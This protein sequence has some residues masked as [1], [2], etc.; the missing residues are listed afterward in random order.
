MVFFA[1]R[2]DITEE[3]VRLKSHVQKYY[4]LLEEEEPGRALDF[5]GQEM[6]REATTLSS[7]TSDLCISEYALSLKIEISKIREQIMNIE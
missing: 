4:R 7:K 6:N 3:L 2:A 5:L 1:E